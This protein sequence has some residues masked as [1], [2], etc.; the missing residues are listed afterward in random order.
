MIRDPEKPLFESEAAFA[1][2]WKDRGTQGEHCRSGI[3]SGR[4]VPSFFFVYRVVVACFSFSTD[5]FST[6]LCPGVGYT[7]DG[8]A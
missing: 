3:F 1:Q 7:V 5:F 8:G 2:L 6:A 4:R